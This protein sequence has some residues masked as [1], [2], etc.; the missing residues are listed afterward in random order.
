M[1]QA[2][3]KTVPERAHLG[4]WSD[5][6]FHSGEVAKFL[7]LRKVDVAKIAAVA[8]ASV[9]FDHKAPKEV[10][11]RLQEIGNICELVAQYFEGDAVKTALWF[12]T[13][14][15]MLGNVSPRDMI[16]FGRYQKLHRFI[17]EALQENATVP[18]AAPQGTR[19]ASPATAAHS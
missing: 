14:N 6:T 7:D 19:E 17:V 18:A 12:K 4:F 5:H 2:L 10:L 1:N 15:P 16:R 8:P 9:R 3:F 13:A 11:E